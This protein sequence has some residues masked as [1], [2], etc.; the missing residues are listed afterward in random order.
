MRRSVWALGLIAILAACGGGGGGSGDAIREPKPELPV[1]P[2]LTA[3]DPEYHL[4]TPRFT[5]HQPDVL[6]QIG[7]HYAYAKGL[8]GQ[9][10]RIGIDDTIVDYTQ[11][12]EFRS[13]VK[14]TDADGATLYYTR[15]MGTT[16]SAMWTTVLLTLAAKSGEA[17]AA[18]TPKS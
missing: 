8:T 15:L 16:C 2:P 3:S 18:E 7:A 14:L 12:A 10:V 4:G 1:S 11:S 6:E 17:T 13:R 9:G 5:T